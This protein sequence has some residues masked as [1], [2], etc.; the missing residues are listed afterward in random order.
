MKKVDEKLIHCT[1]CNKTHI[2][3]KCANITKMK[4]SDYQINPIYI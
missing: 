2:E 1:T 4:F 3:T